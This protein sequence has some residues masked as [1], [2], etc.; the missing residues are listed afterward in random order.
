[1]A[2]LV[3]VARARAEPQRQ[4][5]A[6]VGPDGGGG[7]PGGGQQPAVAGSAAGPGRQRAEKQRGRAGL[8]YGVHQPDPLLVPVQRGPVGEA[9]GGGRRGAGDPGRDEHA[10]R[11]FGAAERLEQHC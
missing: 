7:E 10:R 3:G 8:A 9:G 2:D 5:P 1:V 4:V 11:A 6:Q